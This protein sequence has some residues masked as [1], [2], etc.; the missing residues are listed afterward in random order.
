[1]ARIVASVLL[2]GMLAT[3]V[4]P[5]IV[6]ADDNQPGFC[7]LTYAFANAGCTFLCGAG[8]IP[9]IQATTPGFVHIKLYCNGVVYADCY[10][11]LY[12]A[13]YGPAPADNE[14]GGCV[15]QSDSS[16]VVAAYCGAYP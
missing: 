6:T 16:T 7:V 14:G 3:S 11:N 15:V 1:M 2:M 12:C 5:I 8:D 9:Q 4:L 13:A 10:S